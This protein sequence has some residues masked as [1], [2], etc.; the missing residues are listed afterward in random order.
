MKDFDVIIIGSGIGG[1]MSAG[2]LS[3]RGLKVLLIERHTAP[4]GYLA[5]FRRKGYLFDAAVDCIAGAAPGGL[6]HRALELLEVQDRIH[7]VRVDPVR[8]SIFPGGGVA[9]DGDSAAYRE[10]LSGLFPRE[11]E[12]IGHLLGRMDRVYGELGSF[13]NALISG[14]RRLTVPHPGILQLMGSS[15]AALLDDTIDDYRLKAILSDRC[16]FIGLP[17][18]KVSA[19]AM[20]SLMMSY[21]AFGAYRPAGGFQRLADVFVEGIR[22]RGGVVILNRGVR[23]ILLDHQDCCRGVLCDNGEEYTSRY[24]ISNIDLIQTFRELLGGR[25]G[26]FADDLLLSPGVST[27]FFVVYAGMRGSGGDCSSIGYFPS[28]AMES[29]FRADRAFAEDSTVG[30]TMAS[31]DDPSRAPEGCTTVVL[32]ELLETWDTGLDKS[33]CADAV[34]RKAGR[35]IPGI[36]DRIEIVEA[37]TPHTFCRYTGNT[38]GAAFGWRQTPGFR[39]A[40]RHGIP[41]LYIA[42][43]WGDMGG[44]VLGAAYSGARAAGDVLSREGIRDVV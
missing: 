12:G 10:R 38:G 2:L 8:M 41:N 3:A 23:R 6:I 7:F 33:A 28:Y 42:G 9:V 17:P 31:I 29:F 37:A 44:G 20:V 18:T 15:Y 34:I 11:R 1:L 27:S 32:H 35:V 40:R 39:G 25:Y 24:I 16:P 43:H 30:I 5:S 14:D 4:G 19:L 22:E 26:S 13:L 21:F 36:E